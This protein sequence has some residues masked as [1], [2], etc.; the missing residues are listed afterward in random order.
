MPRKGLHTGSKQSAR[1]ARFDMGMMPRSWFGA[2]VLLQIAILLAL[3]TLK[4]EALDSVGLGDPV[5]SVKSLVIGL[6]SL[7]T[8]THSTRWLQRFPFHVCCAL[9]TGTARK[10]LRM[11]IF[12]YGNGWL[13]VTLHCL[14]SIAAWKI[15]TNTLIWSMAKVGHGTHLV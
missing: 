3:V 6:S 4:A 7:N 12:G 8:S 11:S 13:E 2:C 14:A 5:A 1:L 10:T 15:I 9:T